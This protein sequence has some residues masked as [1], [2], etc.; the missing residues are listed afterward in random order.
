MKFRK[1]LFDIFP[2]NGEPPR[3]RKIAHFSFSNSQIPS[4]SFLCVQCDIKESLQE[5]QPYFSH[6][7]TYSNLCIL[8]VPL[9]FETEQSSGCMQLHV[10]M[11]NAPGFWAEPCQSFAHHPVGSCVSSLRVDSG[12]CEKSAQWHLFNNISTIF[13]SKSC[14]EGRRNCTAIFYPERSGLW[15]PATLS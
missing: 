12:R 5:L 7:I 10:G 1:I 8:L 4:P 15:D 11:N 6:L 13:K 14:A 2:I 9:S 3:R